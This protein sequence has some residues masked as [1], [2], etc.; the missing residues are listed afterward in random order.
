MI[1][2]MRSEQDGTLFFLHTKSAT[3]SLLV[4]A[5][6][7]LLLPYWGARIKTSDISYIVKELPFVSYMASTEGRKNFQL[8]NLPQPY[9]SFGN[10]DLR[11]PA[12]L[13]TYEDGSRTTDLS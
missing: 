8:G 9:P 3:L 4:S 1:E 2:T 10:S 7:F 5:E 13:F 11:S 6:G 12:F